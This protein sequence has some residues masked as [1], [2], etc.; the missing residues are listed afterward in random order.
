MFILFYFK[1]NLF[2]QISFINIVCFSMYTNVVILIQ[3]LFKYNYTQSMHFLV[4]I[5]FSSSSIN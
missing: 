3:L 4:T 1:L 5:V 2:L